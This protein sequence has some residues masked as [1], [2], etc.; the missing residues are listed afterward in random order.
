MET[1]NRSFAF[2]VA[3]TALISY[4]VGSLVAVSRFKKDTYDCTVK[5]PN[6]A[7]SIQINQTCF[8]EEK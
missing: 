3:L 6:M 1:E 2:A 8:C 4:M 5:C 7:H